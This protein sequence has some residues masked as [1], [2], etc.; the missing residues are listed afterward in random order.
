MKVAL[1]PVFHLS[2]DGGF[3]ASSFAFGGGFLVI[4]KSFGKPSPGVGGGA[5]GLHGTS[6]RLQSKGRRLFFGMPG[7]TDAKNASALNVVERFR[8]RGAALGANTG[9]NA[10]RWFDPEALDRPPGWQN[11]LWCYRAIT[12]CFGGRY[13]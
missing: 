1:T 10:Q 6:R 8:F 3:H 9:L 13:L 4:R 7:L 11:F 5:L 12:Y 2:S